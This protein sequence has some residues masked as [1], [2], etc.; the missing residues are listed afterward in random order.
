MSQLEIPIFPADLMRMLGI[1]HAST[2]L[3]QIKA[4]KVPKPDVQISQKTR[5][6]H[7]ATL[8]KA[9]LIQATTEET[10]SPPSPEAFAS[11]P[12]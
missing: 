5:Y 3:K 11:G 8:V 2:L 1:T 12:A 9:N 10:A 7:R 4:G 6:W